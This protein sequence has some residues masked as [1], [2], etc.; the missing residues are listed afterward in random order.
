MMSWT[1]HPVDHIM[2]PWIHSPCVLE[3]GDELRSNG[4]ML[5]SIAIWLYVLYPP[6]LHYVWCVA[7]LILTG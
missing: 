2:D 1:T 5:S 4:G 6:H 7:V 3:D